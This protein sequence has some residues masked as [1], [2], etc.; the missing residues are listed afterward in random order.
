MKANHI[1]LR[2]DRLNFPLECANVGKLSSAVFIIGGDIPDDVAGLAVEIEYDDD[3]ETARYTAA[4]MRQ[5]DGT[6]RAYIAPAYFPETSNA[7]KYHIVATD[8]QENPRWLGSGSLRIFDNPANGSHVVPD[9]LPRNLYA[10]NPT[11]GLYYKVTA[12]V[13]EYGQVSLSTEQEGVTL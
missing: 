6:F 9:I 7:L 13:N 11:T 10:Y 8:E 4:A 1:T 3:G 5:P 2:P 12:E